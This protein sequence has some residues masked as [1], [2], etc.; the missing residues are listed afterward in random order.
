MAVVKERLS[1]SEE[2]L[3]STDIIF[4]LAG[5]C[6]EQ[7]INYHVAD[8]ALTLAEKIERLRR[9][10]KITKGTYVPI[11]ADF[12]TACV[13]YGGRVPGSV[14][15]QPNAHENFQMFFA[16]IMKF[17]SKQGWKTVLLIT[18]K[19]LVEEV[20]AAAKSAGFAVGSTES[21]D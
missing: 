19:E 10:R 4:A 1:K 6:Y 17:G 16:R 12:G 18:P 5:H 8:L 7:P 13:I 14:V 15:F 21:M 2:M 9:T 20:T 11:A 3:A